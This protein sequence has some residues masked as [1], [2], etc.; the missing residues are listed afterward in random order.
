MNVLARA[1][2]IR[3]ERDALYILDLPKLGQMVHE[4]LGLEPEEI[5]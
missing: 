3:Q 4:V 2:V 5:A 1:G